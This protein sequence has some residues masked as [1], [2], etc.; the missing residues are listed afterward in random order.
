MG[1]K[2]ESEVRVLTLEYKADGSSTLYRLVHGWTLLFKLGPSLLGKKVKL[3]TNYPING[4]DACFERLKYYEV[5]WVHDGTNVK[6]DTSKLAK[7]FLLLGGSFHYYLI[8]QR[9]KIKTDFKAIY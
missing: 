3:F 8:D 7:I 9:Y 6:D 5:S 4:K 2:K 1:Y